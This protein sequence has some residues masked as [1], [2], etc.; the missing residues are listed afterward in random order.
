M[1]AKFFFVTMALL[2]MGF[3]ISMLRKGRVKE[4]YAAL[5][6]IV[7]ILGIVLALFPPLL[8]WAAGIL[9]I[10]VPSNLLFI[11]SIV[12]LLAVALHLSVEISKQEDSNRVLAENIAI[13]NLV[14]AE[15]GLF[16]SD[17]QAHICDDAVDSPPKSKRLEGRTGN[18]DP[19]EPQ[20]E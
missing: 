19:L 6:L 11:L 18:E 5:W 13:L 16:S 2:I 15:A 17:A 7:G 12:F 3:I 9:G 1:I 14:I 4:K 10:E 8:T 20:R